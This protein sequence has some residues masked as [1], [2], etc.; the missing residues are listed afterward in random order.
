MRPRANSVQQQVITPPRARSPARPR[1]RLLV[2]NNCGTSQF[3]ILNYT[4]HVFGKNT[5]YIDFSVPFSRILLL[6]FL[7]KRPSFDRRMASRPKR[8]AGERE[9]TNYE[10]EEVESK[11]GTSKNGRR[12]KEEPDPGLMMATDI[13][14]FHQ[15]DGKQGEIELD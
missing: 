12:K 3:C 5:S 13:D 8:T 10:P 11:A 6:H 4:V 1:A 14:D 7:R 2:K 9:D 15:P